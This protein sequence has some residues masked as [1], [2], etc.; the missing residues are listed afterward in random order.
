MCNK[1]NQ[2]NN[3][4]LELPYSVK[5]L[6]KSIEYRYVKIVWTEKN[7]RKT[8][9]NLLRIKRSYFLDKYNLDDLD[10]IFFFC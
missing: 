10:I 4:L 7:P 9:S 6:Y 2:S 1:N 3:K 5:L 8:S